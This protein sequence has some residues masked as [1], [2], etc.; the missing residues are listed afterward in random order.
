MNKFFM[1][2]AVFTVV[3]LFSGCETT[4]GYD[5]YIIYRPAPR[6]YV[7]PPPVVYVPPQRVYVYPPPVI[8][9]HNRPP[10]FNIHV[11]PRPHYQTPRVDHNYHHGRPSPNIRGNQPNHNPRREP[12]RNQSPSRER[13]NRR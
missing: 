6:V 7:A 4:D 2:L 9:H 10:Q 3:I 11:H 8:H 12:Q 5:S 13:S 1:I